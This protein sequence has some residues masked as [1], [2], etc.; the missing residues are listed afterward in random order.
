MS[1]NK[2]EHYKG[3]NIKGFYEVVVHTSNPL[4][5]VT[6]L[7]G[8][9]FQ[10][11]VKEKI[12]DSDANAL[13]NLTLV[14]SGLEVT[15]VSTTN[16]RVDFTIPG[17]ATENLVSSGSNRNSLLEIVYEFNATYPGESQADVLDIGI[18][19]INTNRVLHSL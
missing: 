6:D 19:K 10:L 14:N 16:Y 12:T 17:E 1:L 9:T 2:S 8:T 3:E 4:S 5:V 15:A 7:T 13:A 18:I 11:I